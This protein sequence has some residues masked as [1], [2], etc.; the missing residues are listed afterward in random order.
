MSRF[1]IH[2]ARG[3]MPAL[4]LCSGKYGGHTTCFSL[5]TE[6]GILIIDAGT[7]IA[8]LGNELLEQ[9]PPKP[10]CIL[11]THFHLDH[12][13]GLP[14]FGPL[15]M[16][17][18]AIRIV[19]DPRRAE[20]WKQALTTWFAPPY[21]PTNLEHVPAP[22]GLEDLDR[23][24]GEMCL[25]GVS[26]SWCSLRHPQASL[27]YRLDTAS[28]SVVIAT[29]HEAGDRE[30]D[31]ALAAFCRGADVLVHDAHYTDEEAPRHKG[32]GHATWRD[33]AECAD[34][35]G[36]GQL[37]LTHHH[38]DRDD[39]ELDSIVTQ[40]R[41]VFPNTA[42]AKE[43]MTVGSARHQILKREPEEPE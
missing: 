33:A 31:E 24:S 3:T 38:P 43:N 10:V 6:A 2:G 21:W 11:F 17:G 22:P 23:R 30:T 27:A 40:A 42:A 5:E 36:V 18:A 19:G 13:M 28:L 20:D 25:R 4:T 37:V 26:V 9:S 8:A 15:Y 12:V 16:E 35:A 34:R 7:G 39:D 14:Y 1:R 32:W 29:D 41:Q